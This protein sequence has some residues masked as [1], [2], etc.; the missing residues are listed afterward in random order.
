MGLIF[1][2]SE[3][4]LHD[5]T[6]CNRRKFVTSDNSERYIERG[7]VIHTYYNPLVPNVSAAEQAHPCQRLVTNIH[8]W[9]IIFNFPAS[10]LH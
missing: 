10:K 2:F 1:L 7:T 5:V 3:L 4:T 8:C 6:I 9:E